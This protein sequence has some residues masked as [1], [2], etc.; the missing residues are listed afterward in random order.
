M[1]FGITI[2]ELMSC[3][4]YCSVINAE[5]VNVPSPHCR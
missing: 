3:D 5:T 1:M 4:G 2:S